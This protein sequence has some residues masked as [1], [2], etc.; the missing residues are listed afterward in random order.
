MPGWRSNHCG[1]LYQCGGLDEALALELL[2]HPAEDVRNW[3]VRLLGDDKHVSARRGGEL[4]GARCAGTEPGRAQPTGLHGTAA[5]R[6]RGLPVVAAL[7]A[8]DEDLTDPHIPL[9]LWWAVE[10]KAASDREQVLSLFSTRDAWAHPLSKD[11]VLP[12]LARRYAAGATTEDFAAC[13]RLLA[14]APGEAEFDALVAAMDKGLQGRKLDGV[15]PALQSIVTD[16]HIDKETRTAR[17]RF[18]V[19][20]G[21]HEAAARAL[22]LLA[23]RQVSQQGPA[24]SN[25]ACRTGRQSGVR[26]SSA[27]AAE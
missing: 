27:V 9:L 22:V 8:R 20:L 6:A 26:R 23:D 5:P 11:I 7:L 3:T 14:T 4:R 21:S 25:R 1:A 24:G 17:I 16:L 10:D 19:R 18:A 15:P 12:R 13:A 2:A